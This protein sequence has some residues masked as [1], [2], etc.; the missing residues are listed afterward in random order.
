VTGSVAPCAKSRPVGSAKTCSDRVQQL[1]GGRGVD[2]VLDARGGRSWRDSYNCLAPTGRLAVFGLA[3]AVGG[4]RW[5]GMARALLGVPWL[6]F[7]P[8]S[9]NE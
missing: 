5:L 9:A 6:R 2:L 3:T 1:T 4:S 7:N 8:L